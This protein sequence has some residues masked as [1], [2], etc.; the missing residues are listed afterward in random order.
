MS[1]K[2]S[3]ADKS[4]GISYDSSCGLDNIL[5]SVD[6]SELDL[7]E[8]VDLKQSLFVI[9]DL[10][11]NGFGAE[12]A[13]IC[14]ISAKHKDAVFNAYSLPLIKMSQEAENVTG[15]KII[16]G[17]MFSGNE[18]LSTTPIKTVFENFLIY[19]KSFNSPIILIAHNGFR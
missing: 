19:S 4:E 6:E 5:E 3:S 9:V 17:E 15:L 2:N 12:K 7:I 13:E 11:T 8:E 16:R 10:E 18:K 1:Q 14:Q